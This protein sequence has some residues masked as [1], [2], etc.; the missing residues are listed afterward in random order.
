MMKLQ[1]RTE[2]LEEIDKEFV[3]ETKPLARKL[4]GKAGTKAKKALQRTLSNVG[5]VSPPG[6]PPAEQEGHL[7]RSIGRSKVKTRD[8]MVA[9]WVGVG[10]G[11]GY[12]EVNKSKSQGANPFEYSA[13]QEYGGR[14][15]GGKRLLPRPFI[16]PTFRRIEPE[17]VRDW[18]SEL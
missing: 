14:I 4:V 12:D 5:E 18:E 2:G 6:S 3:D 11:A 17:I 1:G 15:R 8:N 7:R 9:C 10:E 13:V 16:R